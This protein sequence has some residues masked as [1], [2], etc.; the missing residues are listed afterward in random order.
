MEDNV[1]MSKESMKDA[2]STIGDAEYTL[3]YDG[4]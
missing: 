3:I 4:E 1:L 2:I